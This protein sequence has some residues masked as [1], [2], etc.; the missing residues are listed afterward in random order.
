MWRKIEI[1]GRRSDFGNLL[2]AK[3]VKNF[4]NHNESA[5]KLEKNSVKTAG[6]VRKLLF[7]VVPVAIFLNQGYE[8]RYC[9]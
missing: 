5:L 4:N 8:G 3:L 7:G 9:F 2:Y 6:E 1:R